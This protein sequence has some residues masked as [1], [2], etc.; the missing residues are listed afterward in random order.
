MHI[1][2]KAYSYSFISVVYW[3]I[4]QSLYL[5]SNNIFSFNMVDLCVLFELFLELWGYKEE[6]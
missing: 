6:T 5:Q 2:Y 1:Y 3:K 4:N